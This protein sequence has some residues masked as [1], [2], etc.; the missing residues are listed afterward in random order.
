MTAVASPHPVFP[1]ALVSLDR[2]RFWQSCW[3]TELGKELR[4]TAPNATTVA[5]LEEHIAICAIAA[6][7]LTGRR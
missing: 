6:K 3:F 4:K 7:T 1:E 2:V 5:N